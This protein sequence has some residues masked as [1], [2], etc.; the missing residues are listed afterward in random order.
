MNKKIA[1]VNLIEVSMILS[2]E[3]KLELVKR[4]PAL[5]DKQVDAL[6]TYFAHERQYVLEHRDELIGQMTQ[7]LDE[8]ERETSTQAVGVGKPE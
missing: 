3:D 5:N 4:V 6:G 2:D 1:L 8:L 7:F